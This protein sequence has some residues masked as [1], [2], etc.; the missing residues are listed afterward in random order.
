M[1]VVGPPPLPQRGDENRAIQ[2]NTHAKKEEELNCRILEHTEPREI[3][4]SH[5]QEEGGSMCACLEAH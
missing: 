4:C 3:R 1:D 2:T 5:G